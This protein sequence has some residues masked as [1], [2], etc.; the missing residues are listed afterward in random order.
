MS[1]ADSQLDSPRGLSLPGLIQ[2]AATVFGPVAVGAW[3]SG[4]LDS[5]HVRGIFLKFGAL[6]PGALPGVLVDRLASVALSPLTAG[7]LGFAAAG[8][9]S[10]LLLRGAY[11]V[12]R[13]R[14]AEQAVLG[15]LIALV[16]WGQAHLIGLILLA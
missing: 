2:A 9:V 3:T 15:T 12:S 10:L 7:V 16:C 8:V 11:G 6:A 13:M 1:P 5:D 14:P 4:G